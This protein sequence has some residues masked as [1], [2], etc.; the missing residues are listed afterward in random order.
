MLYLLQ[1]G[2]VHSRVINVPEGLSDVLMH[3]T[4]EVLCCQSHANCFCQFIVDLLHS[5]VA[6]NKTEQSTSLLR[7]NSDISKRKSKQISLVME[8]CFGHFLNKRL[9]NV[10]RGHEFL[11]AYES[12][13]LDELINKCRISHTEL[14]ISHPAVSASEKFFETYRKEKSS[15]SVFDE[16]SEMENIENVKHKDEHISINNIFDKKS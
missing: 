11:K 7:S 1:R 4:R 6:K 12:N 10:G 9:C 3:I 8:K 5:K 15:Y 16:H 2:K 14:R 13:V